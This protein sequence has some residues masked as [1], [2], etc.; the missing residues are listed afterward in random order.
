MRS[1]I[2]FILFAP[3]AGTLAAQIP[4]IQLHGIVNAASY[5]AP[6]LSGGSIAQGSMFT[7]FGSI[8]G[9][10]QGV[11]AAAFSLGATLSSFSITVS[12]GSTSIAVLPLFVSEGQINALMPSNAPLGWASVRVTYNSTA[13][14]YA[15]VYI[16]DD[17]LGIFTFTG[18]GLGPAALQKLC[19][20]IKHAF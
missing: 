12:R 18:T 15:P 11:A 9:P 3:I 20:L 17:S 13:S 6:G 7:I 10:V 19:K 5:A 14:N 8:L 1:I 4:A 2:E 16:V